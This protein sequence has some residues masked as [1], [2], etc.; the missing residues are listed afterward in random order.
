MNGI[1]ATV[2][3]SNHFSADVPIGAGTQSVGVTATDANGTTS[4]GK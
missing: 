4:R 1:T 2:D 3:A